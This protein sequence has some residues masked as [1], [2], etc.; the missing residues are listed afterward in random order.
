MILGN[1]SSSYAPS[2][3]SSPEKHSD[4]PGEFLMSV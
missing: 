3:N 4:G 2:T 1:G